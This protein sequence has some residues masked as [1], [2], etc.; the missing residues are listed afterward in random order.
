MMAVP[1]S[2]RLSYGRWNARLATAFVSIDGPGNVDLASITTADSPRTETASGIGDVFVSAGYVFPLHRWSAWWEPYAKLKLPT[3]D[4]DKGLGTGELDAELGGELSRRLGQASSAFAKAFYRWRGDP[5]DVQ[6]QNGVG[7]SVGWMQSPR[8]DWTAGLMLDYRHAVTSATSPAREITLF[9]THKFNAQRSVTFYVLGGLSN[10]S[11]DL[12]G[13][14]QFQVIR[15][16]LAR[17]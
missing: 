16:E 14:V 7:G 5:P 17:Q 3:G 6:L 1:A 11:P 2:Y 9:A 10:A 12:G 15:H 8:F 13:G 4:E